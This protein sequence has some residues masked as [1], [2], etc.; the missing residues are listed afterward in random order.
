MPLDLSEL[1][2]DA[3]AVRAAVLD[4]GRAIEDLAAANI[5]PGDILLKN[6]GVKS[7]GRVVFYDYDELSLLTEVNF[8]ALP[9]TDDVYQEVAAE[10]WFYVGE[11]DVFPEE[12]PTFIALAEPYRRLLWEEHGAIFTV[13]FWRQMQRRHRSGELIRVLPYSRRLGAPGAPS[14]E[15]ARPVV[16]EA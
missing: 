11:H 16:F 3:A 10:P 12:F 13:S 15:R 6:F 7:D 2:R 8:R 5:F 4:Y 14:L 1:E 9:S